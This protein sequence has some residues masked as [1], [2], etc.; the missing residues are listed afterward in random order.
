MERGD[1]VQ[2]KG[3]EEICLKGSNLLGLDEGSKVKKDIY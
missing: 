3:I 2:V 1:M